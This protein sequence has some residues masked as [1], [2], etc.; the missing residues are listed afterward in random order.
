MVRPRGI[1]NPLSKRLGNH[2]SDVQLVSLAKLKRAAD[3]EGRDGHG[4]YVIMQTGYDPEDASM[5]VHDYLLGRS[6]AWLALHWFLRMP[7]PERRREFVFG[8]KAEVIAQMEKLVGRIRV[9]RERPADVDEEGEAD[10]DWE[11]VIRG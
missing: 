9:I 11:R 8:T 1:M 4:P 3:F 7:V 10:S 5:R 2:F 6:G